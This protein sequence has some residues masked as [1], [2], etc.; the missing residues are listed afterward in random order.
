MVDIQTHIA[1]SI[2]K[3][4]TE[5]GIQ[6]PHA[7]ID[8]T[9]NLEHG[10]YTSNVAMIY[11]K[12][13]GNN[14]R[15]LAEEIVQKLGAI[16]GVADISIAG[17]GFINFRL[18]DSYIGHLVSHILDNPNTYGSNT[19]GTGKKVVVEY[20]SP[21][22]AKPFSIGHLRSTIIGDALAN[23]L[24]F[25]GYEVVRHNYLGDWGTQFGK[26]LY[27]LTEWSSI[28]AI[29]K[30][31]Q[32]IKDLVALYVRFHAEAETD[33]TLEDKGREWFKKLEDG[34]S[35]ARD[36][37]QKCIQ[38]SKIEFDGIYNRLGVHFDK[39]DGESS[40]EEYMPE[41]LDIVTQKGIARESEGAL[42][43]FFP[44]DMY[45]PFLIRRSDGATLYATRDLTSD[46]RRKQLYG[47]DVIIINEVGSEQTL[48]FKQLFETEKMLGWFTEG[49][50]VHTTHGLYRF[51][52][53]KMSTRKG[54]VIWLE[55][56]LNEAAE[57]A[58][59]INPDV[60]ER[61]AIGAIKFNDLKRESIK[62]I[63]FNWDEIVNL[64]GDTGPYVQYT[65]ARICA[66]SEKAREQGILAQTGVNDTDVARLLE[67]F[68]YIVS[69]STQS[70]KANYIAEYLIQL[71]GAFNA[72]YA[73]N[74]IVDDTDMQKSAE[75][76]A[77]AQ[78]VGAVLKTGMQ[79]LG[80]PVIERM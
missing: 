73:G 11:A 69:L 71:A 42:A 75:R 77:L 51:P 67:R 64:K 13:L 59:L 52:E 56:I 25:S 29:E 45:P 68:P 43:V 70:Y 61:V 57:K 53:G 27:A 55:D 30:S 36:L 19:K 79:I 39:D 60:A 76:L 6:K 5:L 35:V 72:Y 50:R 34:D 4:L 12:E 18:E 31:D 20:S 9:G 47:D 2:K 62:S 17:P 15:A 37:W 65:Y 8:I 10:D 22:I 41:V 80:V 46:Y 74:V 7:V 3:V 66:L 49:Q 44:D 28:E 32:K 40:L 78:A 26:L 23:V 24:A 21:N 63:V 1:D 33:T 14:P 58:R 48:H 16:P 38:W 54:N